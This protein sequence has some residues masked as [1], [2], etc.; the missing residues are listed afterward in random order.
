M[1]FKR[2]KKGQFV[3]FIYMVHTFLT[4]EN[5]EKSARSLNLQRLRKQCVEAYQIFCVLKQLSHICKL[6]KWPNCI[7]AKMEEKKL[8]YKIRAN[9]HNTRVQWA[10]N[11]RKKYLVLPYRYMVNGDDN[12]IEKINKNSLPYKI[13]KTGSKYELDGDNV[14]VWI[15]YSSK[16]PLVYITKTEERFRILYI[17]NRKDIAL[18]QDKVYNLGFSQHAIVKM[19]AGYKTSLKEYINVHVGIYCSMK[20]KN[21]ERCTM[22]I[23]SFIVISPVKPWWLEN[24]AVINS[25]RASLLRKEMVRKEPNHFVNLFDIDC[26]YYKTGYV[27]SGSIDLKYV[28]KLMKHKNAFLTPDNILKITYPISADEKKRKNK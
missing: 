20:K 17:I 22:D 16:Q 27:W 24:D 19:W 7:K 9:L 1:I 3:N 18:P 21:G 25:H 2:D 23:P 11:T 12:T 28:K 14:K 13:Y 26:N 10:I 8:D 4:F 6:K 5:Y 15:K